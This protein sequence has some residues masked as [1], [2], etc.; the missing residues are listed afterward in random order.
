MSEIEI[1]TSSALCDRIKEFFYSFSNGKYVDKIDTL[2]GSNILIELY[3]LFDYDN[4]EKNKDRI[5]LQLLLMKQTKNFLN[6]CRRAVKEIKQQRFP[7][8]EDYFDVDIIIDKSDLDISVQQAIG[9]KFRNK[10]VSLQ[11]LV[12]GESQLITKLIRAFYVCSEGHTTF[13]EGDKIPIVCDEKTCKDRNLIL[14]EEKSESTTFRKYYLREVNYDSKHIDTLIA[15][16]YGEFANKIS[17]GDTVELVGSIRLEKQNKM[18][19]NVFEIYN[20]RKLEEKTYDITEEDKKIFEHYP[21]QIGFYAKLVDSIAP[22]IYKSRL[23]KEAFLLSYVGSAKW[24]NNQRY[25]INTLVVG[26]PA[27]A[28]SQ[29]AKWGMNTLPNVE[30]V[31]SKGASAKGL[32]A[33][34][35][36]QTDGQRVLE[37]GQICRQSGKGLVAIDEFARMPEVFDAFYT[38]MDTGIFNSATV[39][40]HAELKAETPIYATGNPHRTNYWNDDVSLIEN[41]HRFEPALLSRFDLIIICKDDAIGI[42]RKNIA[43]K[44]AGL[45]EVNSNNSFEE[46]DI[47]NEMDLAKFL[48]YSKSIHPKLTHDVREKAV[49]IFEDIM[50]KKSLSQ[51]SH[52]DLNNRVVSTILRLTLAISRVHLHRETTLEDISLAHQIL[53][54]MYEQRGLQISNSATYIERI[55]EKIFK[56]LEKT[57]LS[58]TDEEIFDTVLETNSDEKDSILNDVGENG[59]SRINNKKWRYIMDNVEKSYMIEIVQRKNP[60]RLRWRKEQTNLPV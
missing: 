53:M 43:R 51:L 8:L 40:G 44:I 34:Q 49:E 22:H 25:W 32:F 4:E 55:A 20:S 26:D 54:A 41:L 31:S 27:T 58:M 29:I 50:A 46:M 2:N 19:Y 12:N 10:L 59:A 13:V 38:P 5:S 33:G 42:D 60:R 16:G 6:A 36:E 11:A 47:F 23:Q 57:G 28:K 24:D 17:I 18:L 9:H 56:V 14:D 37:I 15:E 1:L 52:S 45:V 30:F 3:D 7:D 39:G 21:K 48:L 35:K